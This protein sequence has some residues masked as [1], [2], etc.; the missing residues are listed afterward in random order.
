[1]FG[2]MALSVLGT[3]SALEREADRLGEGMGTHRSALAAA[4]RQGQPPGMTAALAAIMAAPG[5]GSGPISGSP[6]PICS[7]SPLTTPPSS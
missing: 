1:M 4:H 6:S 3:A 5:Y 2:A 7:R